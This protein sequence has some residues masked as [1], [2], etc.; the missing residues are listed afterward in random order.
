MTTIGKTPPVEISRWIPWTDLLG[1]GNRF[2]QLLED[3]WRWR[4]GQIGLG[5]ELLEIK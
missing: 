4:P 1:S 5:A 3:A 2:G